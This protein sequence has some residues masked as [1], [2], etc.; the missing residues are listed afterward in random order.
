MSRLISSDT[1]DWLRAMDAENNAQNANVPSIIADTPPADSDTP[2]W[3]R[4][5]AADDECAVRYFSYAAC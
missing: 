4:T 1:P 5:M 2:D 3:L